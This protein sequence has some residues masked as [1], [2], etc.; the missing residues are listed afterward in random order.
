MKKDRGKNM[1]RGADPTAQVIW[2]YRSWGSKK[3]S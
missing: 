1:G 3:W 2:I